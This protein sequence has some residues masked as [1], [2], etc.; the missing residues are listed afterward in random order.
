MCM[1]PQT[2]SATAQAS[3]LSLSPYF[4][5][6]IASSRRTISRKR[7]LQQ[8]G[9]SRCATHT[10]YDQT[11]VSMQHP[12]H[13]QR[14]RRIVGRSYWRDHDAHPPAG[15]SRA[16]GAPRA[17]SICPLGSLSPTIG[18]GEGSEGQDAPVR[19]HEF[20]H[21]RGASK[22]GTVHSTSAAVHHVVA[23]W[24]RGPPSRAAPTWRL[25][26]YEARRR[27]TQAAAEAGARLAH[28]QQC[29]PPWPSPAPLR[30]APPRS[31][32]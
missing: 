15:D 25:Q 30:R 6:A 14:G 9:L 32:P 26:A 10:H 2:R 11:T 13:S 31:S 8:R 29:S 22:R 16:F 3:I 17:A 19:D 27:W 12:D 18:R 23:A 4:A 1:E 20:S 28:A 7:A 21:L 5:S 24:R